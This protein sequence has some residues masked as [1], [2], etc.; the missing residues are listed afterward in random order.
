[1]EA[2][3]HDMPTFTA[4]NANVVDKK[5]VDL[6]IEL[7]IRP[8]KGDVRLLIQNGGVSLNNT[9]VEDVDRCIHAEDLIDG[10]LLLLALGK[11]NKVLIRVNT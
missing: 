8:S 5:L 2:I 10:Q 3:A 9:K 4:D 1:M 6:V 11:K 7:G